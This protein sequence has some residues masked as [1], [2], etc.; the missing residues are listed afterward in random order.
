MYPF[1]FYE[2]PV[3]RTAKKHDVKF[4]DTK[5]TEAK[6]EENKEANKTDNKQEIKDV[7]GVNL[8]VTS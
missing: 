1:P 6:H 7:N 4:I 2:D 3:I 5:I 8:K